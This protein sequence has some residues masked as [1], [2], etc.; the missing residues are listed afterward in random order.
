MDLIGSQDKMAT[1]CS[2]AMRIFTLCRDKIVLIWILTDTPN[3]DGF[4]SY[5]SNLTRDSHL[6]HV[7]IIFLLIWP[8]INIAIC[9]SRFY[10]GIA[11]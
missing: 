1:T 7:N 9:L 8:A 11:N 2:L 3:G 4:L 6:A 10:F 5:L